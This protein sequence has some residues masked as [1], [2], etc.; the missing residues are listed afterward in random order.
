MT[1]PVA[2]VS[3]GS[4][5]ILLST[6]QLQQERQHKHKSIWSSGWQAKQGASCPAAV[7]LGSQLDHVW[8]IRNATSEAYNF[9]KPGSS[10]TLNPQ[11]LRIQLCLSLSKLP[12]DDSTS[13][14]WATM[15]PPEVVVSVMIIIGNREHITKQHHPWLIMPWSP[16]INHQQ[17]STITNH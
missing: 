15:D 12:R 9:N 2:S 5:A 8:T 6:Y 17:S 4:S 14:L 16:T 10:V 13:A 11:E 7:P 3:W 1:A